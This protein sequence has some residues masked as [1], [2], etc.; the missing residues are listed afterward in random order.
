VAKKKSGKS[1]APKLGR[2]DRPG[3]KARRARAYYRRL[4]RKKRII[5]RS[6]GLAFLEAWNS[7][8]FNGDLNRWNGGEV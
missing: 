4:A 8:R 3:P 7:R 2:A 6:N 1:S 5:R